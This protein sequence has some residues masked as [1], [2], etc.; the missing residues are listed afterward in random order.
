VRELENVVRQSLLLARGCGPMP[1]RKTPA[2]ITN[3]MEDYTA[4]TFVS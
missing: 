4:K 1:A 3:G 2:V